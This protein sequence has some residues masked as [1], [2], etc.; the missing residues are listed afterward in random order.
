MGT[1]IYGTPIFLKNLSDVMSSIAACTANPMHLF[2]SIQWGPRIMTTRYNGSLVT[3]FGLGSL[4]YILLRLKLS[5]FSYD[6]YV[7]L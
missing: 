2:N 3:S 7:L 1:S 6:I 5:N 4:T